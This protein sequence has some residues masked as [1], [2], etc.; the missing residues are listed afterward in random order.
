MKNKQ[1]LLKFPPKNTEL[2]KSVIIDTLERRQLNDENPKGIRLSDGQKHLD[3][4][5]ISSIQ[6]NKY[7]SNLR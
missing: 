5:Q 6:T 3:K 1:L 4:I 7:A 2:L